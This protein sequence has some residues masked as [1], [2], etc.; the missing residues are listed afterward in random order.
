LGRVVPEQAGHGELG[1]TVFFD[2]FGGNPKFELSVARLEAILADVVRDDIAKLTAGSIY[3]FSERWPW[4][5]ALT[6]GGRRWRRTLVRW[7]RV[8]CRGSNSGG[9]REARGSHGDAVARLGHAAQGRKTAIHRRAYR[10]KPQGR[11]EVRGGSPEWSPAHRWR[12]FP[13]PAMLSVSLQR[14]S[15]R[16]QHES[17][18]REVT[19]DER[20]TLAVWSL[21]G[22]CTIEVGF[23]WPDGQYSGMICPQILM[24]TYSMLC[25]KVGELYTI[26]ISAKWLNSFDH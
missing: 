11:G 3:R 25:S 19:G 24:V 7:I 12:R 13:L 1:F 17:L 5:W 6:R 23:S 4:I 21:S 8:Q 22:Y 15:G 20:A 26:Y 10:L 9:R 18:R 14:E 16:W 2:W